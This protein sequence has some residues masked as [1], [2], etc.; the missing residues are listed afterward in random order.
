MKKWL[1]YF[2]TASMI[3]PSSFAQFDDD[4]PP[5]PPLP[6]SMTGGTSEPPSI[7]L[8]GGSAPARNTAPTPVAKDPQSTKDRLTRAPI[9][10]I[11]NENFPDTIE[12][13]DFPNADI[14]DI[15]KAMSELTGKNFIIDP[16]VR[17]KITIVAPSK[18]TVAEAYKAFLSALAINGFAVIPSGNF[19]KIRSARNAQRDGIET[20]SGTYFPN[21]DQMITKIIHLKHI[22]A[23]LVNR[24]LRILTSKDGEL[25][26]YTPTNSLIVSD[27]G[28]NVERI[29]K[30]IGQLDVPGFEDQLEVI[31]VRFAKAK[32]I[33]ELVNKIVNKGET[34]RQSGN[35]FS[36]GVPRFPRSSSGASGSQGSAYFMVIPD[37]RTNSLIIVGNKAGI[38]RVRKLVGQLDF[39]IKP[40]E[41]GGVHV[42]YVKYGE[43]EKI[44]DTL[45]GI[46][47][48]AGPKATSGGGAGA[49]GAPLISATSGVQTQTE[50]FGGDVKVTADKGTNSLIV[51]ASKQDYEVVLN[52]LSKID[53]PRDQVY[54]ETVIMEMSA[55]DSFNWE[56]STLQFQ[57]YGKVGFAG[58]SP[59]TLN[60]ILSPNDGSGAILGF[61]SSGTTTVNVPN[62][63]GSFTSVT[64]PS[65]LSFVNFLKKN[66]NANILSNPQ[67]MALDGQESMIRVGDKVVTSVTETIGNATSQGSKTPTFEDASIKITLKPFISQTSNTIRMEIK[68]LIKQL[69]NSP[70]PKAVADSV[71]P[72]AEREFNTT[73]VVPNGDTAV[74]GGLMKENDK[75][76]VSKVP[77]L[78]DI[79][80]LGWL[81]KSR[82]TSKEKANLMIL[83]TP[84]I[85][86]SRGDQ[87]QLLGKKMD[88]R[89]EYIK[90][91]GGL[92]PHGKIIDDLTNK[93][94]NNG[95][96]VK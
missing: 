6:E 66:A 81:F 96:T 48:D 11:T 76:T 21:S 61:A 23:E 16:G 44:K 52:L 62:G 31:P 32:D 73:I 89:L 39:R 18:I 91:V 19:L 14:Q 93:N 34:Q 26:P 28:S 80:I 83:L 17:G 56:I 1:I 2:I 85:I 9:E 78:G 79:P 92:D 35:T 82:T 38:Q 24:D 84:R 71:Q 70:V 63:T 13:F 49:G 50:I 20:Y 4:L 54:V 29:M 90:K 40:D 47:K 88:Q 59:T 27:Y 95:S 37:D 69:G 5:P 33:A 74:I 36:A 67:I 65:V 42:Y 46:A 77:L 45:S 57:S 22:S 12:S 60:S 55:N 15:V 10:D 43:A 30:I 3:S 7:P 25:S 41:N 94:N 72:L 8:R 87:Q 64:L 58:M 68:G 51:V 86:K 75:E 53:I